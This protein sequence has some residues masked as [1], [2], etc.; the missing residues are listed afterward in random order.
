MR[1]VLRRSVRVTRRATRSSATRARISSRTTQATPTRTSARSSERACDTPARW[2]HPPWTQWRSGCTSCMKNTKA[3]SQ[4]CLR[5]RPTITWR[6]PAEDWRYAGE[7][8]DER[9]LPAS[10]NAMDVIREPTR[11]RALDLAV[12]ARQVVARA[13]CLTVLHNGRTVRAPDCTLRSIHRTAD[14]TPPFARR[15]TTLARQVS[16]APAQVPRGQRQ[17]CRG[18][19]NVRV[20]HMVT[21]LSLHRCRPA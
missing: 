18:R 7:A 15:C 21:C 19:W 8:H 4:F 5:V 3:R 16:H 12:R 9:K 6:L 20:H 11:P 14:A 13:P 10:A 1:R 17:V 2:C